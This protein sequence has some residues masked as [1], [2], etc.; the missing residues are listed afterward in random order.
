M[1]SLQTIQKTFHVFQILTKV[2]MILS[3]VWAGLAALGMLCGAV[4][5]HGGT[6]V[7]A[8]R[9]LLFSLTK[10]GGLAEMTGTLLADFIFA[11]TDGIL[12]AFALA[13]FRAEQADGTPFTKRGAVQIRRLGISTIVLPLVAV[14]L[15][16]VV[17]VIFDLPRGVGADWGNLTSLSVGITLILASLIFRYGAELEERAVRDREAGQDR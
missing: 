8:D 9:E 11:L 14:I 15:A 1:K 7:G 13:Y 10:T 4:W 5:Y 6:V 12:L 16:A 2:A 17:A 3:F